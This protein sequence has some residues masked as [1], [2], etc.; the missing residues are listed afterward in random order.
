MSPERVE[1]LR[2]WHEEASVELHRLGAHDVEY[3]DLHLHVP[4]QVFPPTPVSDLLG[5]E[6]LA[7]VRAGQRVLDMGCGAGANAILAARSSDHVVGVDVNPLAVA[8]AA[9]NAERNGVADRTRF[10]ES[11]LCAN[12]DGGFDVIVF[13]PPFRWFRA[14][15]LLERAFADENYRSLTEFMR[16]APH[17]LHA[18]GEV[19]LFFGTSGDVEYLRH[20][21]DQ[22]LLVADT[23]AERSVQA[24]GELVTYFVLR[25]THR[26]PRDSHTERADRPAS[27]RMGG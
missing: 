21:I 18:G 6:V 5:R 20:L 16:E 13:D 17:R 24:R 7:R 3:L 2:R 15:D 25:L 23:I 14:R 11:D 27:S 9:A 10:V 26:R 1:R 19:L 12:V 8:A 4:D 22:S